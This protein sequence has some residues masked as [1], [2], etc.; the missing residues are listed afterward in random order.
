MS[1]QL[2]QAMATG[3]RAIPGQSLTNDPENPAPFEQPPKFTTVHE[4]S[5][6]IFDILVGP[7]V[8]PNILDAIDDGNPIMDIT[9]AILFQ[10]FTE[11]KWN[12]DLMIMLIEPVAY[13]LLALCERFGV[14]PIIYHGE[15]E[16]DE[17]VQALGVKMSAERVD[18]MKKFRE[19]GKVPSGII[20]Q[21]MMEEI[22][23]LPEMDSL[24]G[25]KPETPSL[26]G[27]KPTEQMPPEE[28][29]EEMQ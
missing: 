29:K 17:E 25:S 6:E 8:L 13:M 9:Q 3:G 28:T 16:D 26:L 18:K 10:G 15:E 2:M 24:L 11:G 20:D 7:E 23:A 5:E 4:A 12:G 21:G 19:L 22:E 1:E 27:A 14:E